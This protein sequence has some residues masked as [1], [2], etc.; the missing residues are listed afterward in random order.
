MAQ[1]GKTRDL[2]VTRLYQADIERPETLNRALEDVALALA[3]QDTVGRRWCEREG[4][5]GYTSYA[6]LDDLADRFR[7]F[8]QL[9][10]HLDRHA[11]AFAK[12]LQWELRGLKPVCDSL[13]VSVLPPGGFHGS[14]IHTNSVISG[15]Y[16]VTVP[17]GASAIR[18]E[19]PRAPML[20]AAPPRK[21]SAPEELKV[22]VSFAPKAGSLFLWESWLRHDVPINRAASDRIAVSF[23]YCLG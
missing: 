2:F 21:G 1:N 17:D 18:F 10:K 7:P 19:D 11:A 20:M 22:Q 9:L 5:P 3:E 6:S 13:W 16:Y 15:T 14:H 8:A 4:Y 12:S 23:N